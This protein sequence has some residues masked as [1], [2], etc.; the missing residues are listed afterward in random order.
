MFAC[1]NDL[2]LAARHDVLVF[3]TPPLK[4]DVVIAG[5]VTVDLWISSSA[6]DTDFTAKL[7]DVAPPNKDYPEGYAMNLED[8][9][10]RVRWSEG[11]ETPHFLKPGEVRKVTIDLIGVANRFVKGHRIRVDISSSNFPYFDVNPNTGERPGYSTHSV[12]AI[13]TVYHDGARPSHINLPLLP[14][15]A[16]PAAPPPQTGR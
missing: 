13:N 11:Y 10:I 5:P 1:H 15:G 3:E 6:P 4:S 14:A 7:I 2:P 16:T 8:R 9:I 12:I